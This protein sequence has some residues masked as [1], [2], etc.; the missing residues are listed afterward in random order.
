MGKVMAELK[1]HK[2]ASQIDMANASSYVKIKLS[3]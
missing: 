2:S 1:K 3:N